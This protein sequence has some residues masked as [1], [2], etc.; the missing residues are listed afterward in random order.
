MER[1][2]NTGSRTMRLF[3]YPLKK[4]ISLFKAVGKRDAIACSIH[5][6]PV[7]IRGNLHLGKSSILLCQ[8]CWFLTDGNKDGSLSFGLITEK[9][10]LKMVIPADIPFAGCKQCD[11]LRGLINLVVNCF[12]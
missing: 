7:G 11:N 3:T 12:P 6:K 2:E 10:Y 8:A 4:V 5:Q 9:K 1:S